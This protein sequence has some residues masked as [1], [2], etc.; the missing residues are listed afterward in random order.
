MRIVLPKDVALAA[1][2][3]DNAV[4]K[5]TVE[6][7]KRKNYRLQSKLDQ[8]EVEKEKIAKAIAFL[9]KL[10]TFIADEG[11]GMFDTEYGD[12]FF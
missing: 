9:R 5:R 7:L 1:L 8:Q 10:Q 3:S 12:G 2:Q 6:S 4:L 11:R